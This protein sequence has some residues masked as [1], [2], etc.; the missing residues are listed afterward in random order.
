[1]SADRDKEI[2]FE[3]LR[4]GKV[5]PVERIRSVQ[6]KC[7]R[8][9]SGTGVLGDVGQ[10]TAAARARRGIR[11]D[12]NEARDSQFECLRCGEVTVVENVVM[13]PNCQYC[14]SRDGVVVEG[15]A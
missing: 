15:D 13:R 4:C 1:V 9:G 6:P 10:G 5:S 8:C 11:N 12:R 3:C 14:G 7:A 2:R